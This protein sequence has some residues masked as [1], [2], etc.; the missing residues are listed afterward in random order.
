MI[1]KLMT[2]VAM[3]AAFSLAAPSGATAIPVAPQGLVPHPS[4]EEVELVQESGAATGSRAS[5]PSHVDLVSSL[6][7][8]KGQW[9]ANN[10]GQPFPEIS[11][12]DMGISQGSAGQVVFGPMDSEVIDRLT[13]ELR[14]LEGEESLKQSAPDGSRYAPALSAGI[15]IRGAYIQLN[16]FEQGL[17]INGSVGFISLALCVFGPWWC[18][19]GVVAAAAA[20][21]VMSDRNWLRCPQNTPFLRVYINQTAYSH[22]RS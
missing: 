2:S 22:C 19:L 8:L 18:V 1:R 9:S 4:A 17:V 16:Q 5:A 21:T 12:S 11:L 6:E 10:S 15:D 14:A 20:T 3:L 13:S 7:L